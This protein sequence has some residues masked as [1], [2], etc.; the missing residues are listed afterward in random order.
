MS[1]DNQL[2]S[3]NTFFQRILPHIWASKRTAAHF[4]DGIVVFP[5]ES[6]LAQFR[7]EIGKNRAGA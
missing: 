3:E 5:A 2:G 6:P 4:L 7:D 1:F